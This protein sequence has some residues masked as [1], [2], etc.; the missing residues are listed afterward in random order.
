MP[1][2]TC[3][4]RSSILRRRSAIRR[5]RS[6]VGGTLPLSRSLEDELAEDPPLSGLADEVHPPWTL[7]VFFELQ[8]S[9]VYVVI[10][11]TL[12][13]AP[14]RTLLQPGSFTWLLTQGIHTTYSQP[15]MPVPPQ[16]AAN[17]HQDHN[18]GDYSIHMPSNNG[19]S[20]LLGYSTAM[21]TSSLSFVQHMPENKDIGYTS[22][23]CGVPTSQ[24]RR[25]CDVEW[26]D[27]CDVKSVC[28]REN[29]EDEDDDDTLR[30]ELYLDDEDWDIGGGGPNGRILSPDGRCSTQKP[31]P[32]F[33]ETG[34]VTMG[35]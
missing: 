4:R 7:S 8:Q 9:Q 32:N 26:V 21:H 25:T 35:P 15:L 31:I 1:K 13:N 5:R 16:V 23:E 24:Y 14:P 3:R 12:V 18:V 19:P 30:G 34:L 2:T 33:M 28:S 17:V 6:T 20:T 10:N 29:T 11:S 27:H 22:G